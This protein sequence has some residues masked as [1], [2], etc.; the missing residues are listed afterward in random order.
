VEKNERKKAAKMKL[1]EY[2]TSA[3][4]SESKTEKEKER[5]RRMPR[6]RA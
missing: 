2:Y 3:E 5:T 4:G 1:N 6:V